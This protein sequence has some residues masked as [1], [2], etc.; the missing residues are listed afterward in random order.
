M[1]FRS[2]IF[3]GVGR[4]LGKSQPISLRR[5]ADE[6][7]HEK[8]YVATALAQ[9]RHM[10]GYQVDPVEEILAKR[11][12]AHHRRKISVSGTYHPYVDLTGAALAERLE[13]MLL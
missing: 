3:H 2:E 1:L 13:S 6:M 9:G 10:Q 11:T 8:R 12:V 4:N 7:A 5:S